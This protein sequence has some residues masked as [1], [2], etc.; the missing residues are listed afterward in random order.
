VDM[1]PN[2][3]PYN[4]ATLLSAFT[5]NLARLPCAGTVSLLQCCYPAYLH[6]SDLQLL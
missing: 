6:E 2:T 4:H 5:S 3:L 1:A